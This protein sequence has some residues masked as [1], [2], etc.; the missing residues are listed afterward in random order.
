VENV[1]QDPK[2]EQRDK[3][4]TSSMV[5]CVRAKTTLFMCRA[6]ESVRKKQD[7]VRTM[8]DMTTTRQ[9]RT[10][11]EPDRPGLVRGKGAG[12][13]RAQANSRLGAG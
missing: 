9:D 4:L 12:K 10:A 11:A 2:N 13:G 1:S 5:S 7:L 8:Q 3:H 6:E